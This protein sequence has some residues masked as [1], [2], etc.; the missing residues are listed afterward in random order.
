MITVEEVCAQISAIA[1]GVTVNPDDKL[2]ESGID[3]MT[4]VRLILQLE[5]EFDVILPDALLGPE[6]FETP[7]SITNA[8][9]FS[10][11]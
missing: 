3:S 9:N 4:L 2:D 1:H 10:K 11:G 7:R 5:G 8:L 6:T